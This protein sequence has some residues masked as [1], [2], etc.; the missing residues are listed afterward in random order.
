M[1]QHWCCSST[2]DK[3]TPDTA[4]HRCPHPSRLSTA[5]SAPCRSGHIP[6]YQ[7]RINPSTTGLDVLT[8]P[9]PTFSLNPLFQALEVC[10][11]FLLS[12]GCKEVHH[13]AVDGYLPARVLSP[14]STYSSR[15]E[16]IS[17]FPYG[18][19]EA[20]GKHQVWSRSISTILLLSQPP[21][22][23]QGPLHKEQEAPAS[24]GLVSCLEAEE[25]PQ[26]GA[27]PT[28]PRLTFLERS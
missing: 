26:T 11:P 17:S 23:P 3:P 19:T 24:L 15:L 20:R 28:F 13:L 6:P 27:L 8:F 22:F 5:S 2:Q 1:L 7:L 16:G 10:L 12:S 18:G 4:L 25:E 14:A 21:P 9:H